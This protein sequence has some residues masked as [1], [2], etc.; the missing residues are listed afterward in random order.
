MMCKAMMVF[1]PTTERK[2]KG[3][4]NSLALMDDDD[5]DL[6]CKRDKK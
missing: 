3:A 6:P 1:H 2:M 5:L 4:N